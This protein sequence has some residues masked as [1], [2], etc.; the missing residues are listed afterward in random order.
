MG[1]TALELAIRNLAE[2]IRIQ[3]IAIQDLTSELRHKGGN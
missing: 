1:N 3:T 2:A